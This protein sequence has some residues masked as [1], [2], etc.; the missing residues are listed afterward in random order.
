[1]EVLLLSFLSTSLSAEWGL[2]DHQS[3]DLISVVFLGAIF[4]TLALCPLGDLVG[5]RPVFILTTVT[6]A[7]FGVATAFCSSYG[8][9]LCTRFMVGFGVGGVVVPF[10]TVVEYLPTEYSSSN[11]LVSDIAANLRK[12]INLIRPFSN[13]L[14]GEVSGILLGRWY[15]TISNVCLDD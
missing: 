6:I 8:A 13:I 10:D 14:H 5:R 2:K 11:L 9:L 12:S 7:M 1:M 15:H 3:D 4:G